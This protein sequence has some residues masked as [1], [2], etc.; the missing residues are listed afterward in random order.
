MLRLVTEA[1]VEPV[2]LAEAKAWLDIQATTWDA[3]IL[4][5]IKSARA[6][7]EKLIGIAL[8]Q[9]VYE[10]Y[11]QYHF[12]GYVILPYPVVKTVN[13][14]KSAGVTIASTEYSLSGNNLVFPATN[15]AVIINYTVSAEGTSGE[16]L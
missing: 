6:T 1:T 12:D 2:T 11:I 15:N 10:Y 4:S 16:T 7:I 14:V 13:S 5:G 3:K 8:V 9:S